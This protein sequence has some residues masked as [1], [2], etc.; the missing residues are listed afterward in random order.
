MCQG[1]KNAAS[2][3][4]WSLANNSAPALGLLP[5]SQ[6]STVL[7]VMENSSQP[8]GTPQALQEVVAR[9]WLCAQPPLCSLPPPSQEETQGLCL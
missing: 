4:W 7:V 9:S 2:V 3:R 5:V 8:Y 6:V 1:K